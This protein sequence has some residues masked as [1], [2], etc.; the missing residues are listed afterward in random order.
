MEGFDYIHTNVKETA[1][2]LD[3]EQTPTF[4]GSNKDRIFLKY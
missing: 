1:G 3:K 4:A 2:Y